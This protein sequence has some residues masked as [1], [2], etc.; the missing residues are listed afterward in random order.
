MQHLKCVCFVRPTEGSVR[1]VCD[2]LRAETYGEF[3][4]FFSSVLPDSHLQL[5]AENDQRERIEA[6]LSDK[7]SECEQV[8]FGLPTLS[9]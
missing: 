3:Y 9:N 6:Q 5:L 1:L 8:P 2:L 4:V 7:T